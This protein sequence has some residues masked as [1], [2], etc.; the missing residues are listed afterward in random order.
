ML[1]RLQ[2]LQ[3]AISSRLLPGPIIC[4]LTDSYDSSVCC[5]RRTTVLRD[6]WDGPA[7]GLVWFAIVAGAM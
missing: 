3:T 5:S 2:T 1:L 6:L 4:Q 7:A